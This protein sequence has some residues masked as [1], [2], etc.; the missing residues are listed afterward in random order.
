MITRF[1]SPRFL[2]LAG[3]V[4]L[5][6]SAFPAIR[7]GVDGL[8]LAALSF[9]RLAIAAV[10][11]VAVAPFARVRPP[12]RSD[13]PLI[14]LCGLTGMTAYQILL[15]WGEIH[16]EAGTASLLIAAA[17]VFSI[18][19]GSAFLAEPLTRNIVIGSTIALTGTA[20]VTLAD[21]VS[22]FTAASLVVLAAAVVQG[23]YHCA[24]KPLLRRYTGLE[25]ATYAM[26][27]GTV[28]ALPLMPAAVRAMTQA[29]ADA[30]LSA[31]F[32]GLLPSALGFVIW[33][34]AVARLPLAVSTAAL[35]LVPPVALA[36]SF[37]WLG[38]V[39]HPVELL[40]GGVVVAGVTLINRRR[41]RPVP[42]QSPRY[43]LAP[44]PASRRLD[45]R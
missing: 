38:E 43:D 26:V 3:T 22:G 10:A 14:A 15:N 6:A 36:V 12:K 11:L 16:V 27:A 7:V 34:H 1:A 20:V 25:V 37:V 18:L 19:L 9:L 31:A 5:W 35:Y 23:V 32:L 28:F 17:P 40:G 21:G 41:R 8:G 24:T 30:L 45:R 33:G 39:P 42:P 2:A 29:P 13:L 4:A 44:Q